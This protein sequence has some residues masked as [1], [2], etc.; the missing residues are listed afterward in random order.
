[1]LHQDKIADTSFEPAPIEQGSPEA[2]LQVT[3]ARDSAERQAV[4]QESLK[5]KVENIKSS[6]EKAIEAKA[7]APPEAK[8]DDPPPA[9][10]QVNKK[11]K[12]LD[13]EQEFDDFIASG[14]K[15]ADSEKKVRELYEKAYGLDHVK[16]ERATEK[17]ARESV[18]KNFQNLVNEIQQVSG[19]VRNKD[20]GRLCSELQINR[21]DLAAWLVQQHELEEKLGTLPEPVRKIYNEHGNLKAQVDT[22]SQQLE[23]MKTGTV[24]SAVQA[25]ATELKSSLSEPS[26]AKF[27]TD[28]DTRLGKAGAFEDMVMRHGNNEWQLHQKDLSAKQAVDEVLKILGHQTE[29]PSPVVT[30]NQSATQKPVVIPAPKATVIPNVGQGSASSAMKRPRSLDELRKIAKAM[31]ADA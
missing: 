16:Q 18:E 10:Y 24:D 8:T 6:V 20:F 14:I 19:H 4:E 11:F 21:N 30:P 5:E 7:K 3:Q 2:E 17:A 26:V 23:V 12:V 25:R 13:K 15:D 27:V 9:A 28:F 1:M 29:T 22:L 31:T